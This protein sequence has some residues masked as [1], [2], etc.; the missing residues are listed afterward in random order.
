[1]CCSC[2]DPL[3]GSY[4]NYLAVTTGVVVLASWSRGVSTPLLDGL[5]PGLANMVLLTSL[6]VTIDVRNRKSVPTKTTCRSEFETASLEMWA[7][8]VV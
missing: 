7:V 8:L 2:C 6:A 4:D 5:G 1:V 3:P